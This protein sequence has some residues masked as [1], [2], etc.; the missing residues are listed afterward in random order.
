ML[1]F[2]QNVVTEDVFVLQIL[3][4]VINT[5]SNH[6]PNL[7]SIEVIKMNILSSFE[8]GQKIYYCAL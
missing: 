8:I 6:F 4:I 2:D 5:R 7:N 3:S 1:N